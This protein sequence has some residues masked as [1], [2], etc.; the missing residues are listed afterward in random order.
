MTIIL[1]GRG[2][3]LQFSF[4][5]KRFPDSHSKSFTFTATSAM[6]SVQS[7]ATSITT[8]ATS[9]LQAS[10][11]A[12]TAFVT[13]SITSET[14]SATLV[15]NSTAAGHTVNS[16]RTYEHLRLYYENKNKA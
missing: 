3:T 2:I 11:T 14:T 9:T 15:L 6:V 5:N 4:L 12:S 13:A 10:V 1:G 16:P 7:S 8:S